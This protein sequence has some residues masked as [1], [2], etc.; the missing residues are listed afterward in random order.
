M[1]AWTWLG[2]GSM[3]SWCMGRHSIHWS[4][5]ARLLCFFLVY[6]LLYSTCW[7]RSI[8]LWYC[9]SPL[10]SFII[11]SFPIILPFI[12]SIIRELQIK[13]FDMFCLLFSTWSISALL[14]FCGTSSPSL[15][16]C[17]SCLFP[18]TLAWMQSLLYFFSF[19]FEVPLI[20]ALFSYP[21]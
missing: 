19:L 2:I 16:M 20:S 12:S 10:F 14:V 8:F 5:L 17:S 13:V 4:T 11:H 15:V 9:H 3:T 18:L 6:L 1:Q 21:P 7:K